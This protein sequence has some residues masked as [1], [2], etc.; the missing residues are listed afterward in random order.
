M[1]GILRKQNDLTVVGGNYPPTN[2]PKNLKNPVHAIDKLVIVPEVEDRDA[3][4]MQRVPARV[5]KA[6]GTELGWQAM[7][8]TL[9]VHTGA[10]QG[11]TIHWVHETTA[12]TR[13]CD[14]LPTKRIPTVGHCAVA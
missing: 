1:S 4:I 10:D 14:R 2:S 7:T 9:T 8:Q 12:G 6:V 13:A 11:T 5:I 3:V